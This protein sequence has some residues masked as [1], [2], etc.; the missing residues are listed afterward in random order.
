MCVPGTAEL[1]IR[2]V[3]VMYEKVTNGTISE[4]YRGP[5]FIRPEGRNS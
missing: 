5:G 3:S 4:E 2:S 1:N